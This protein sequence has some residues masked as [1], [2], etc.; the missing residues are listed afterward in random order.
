MVITQE[1][2]K[3]AAHLLQEKKVSVIIGY[4]KGTYGLETS[5]G[6]IDQEKNCTQL[7]FSPLC[8]NNLVTYLKFQDTKKRIGIVVK[9]CD[10]RALVQMIQENKIKREN[11]TI[12]GIPCRGIIDKKKLHKK[13]THTDLIENIE[14]KEQYFKIKISGETLKIPRSELL[15]DKCLTCEYP[16]PLLYDVLLGK[17]I[18]SQV[19]ENYQKI[20]DFEKKSLEKKWE[21]WEKQFQQCIR[22]YACRNI[23]PLCYCEQCTAENLDPRWLRRSVNISENTAWNMIRAYHLAG[24]CIDC[25][26]CERA[27]PMNIPLR[28]LNKKMEKDIKELFSYIPGT[29]IE[30]KPLL[31]TFKPEEANESIL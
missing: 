10:S 29:S 4:K 6:F 9:G 14:E 18:T 21:F 27:C 1:L 20:K 12:I 28:L 15:C 11:L 23:C 2:Q 24:R 22:C 8:V 5:P 3:T 17:P 31:G 19:K 26:E 13:A 30:E 7:M 25:G 16:T